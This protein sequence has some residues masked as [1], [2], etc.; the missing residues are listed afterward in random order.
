MKCNAYY[1]MQNGDVDMAR[2]PDVAGTAKKDIITRIR[3]SADRLVKN[4]SELEAP[5]EKDL[6][7]V[8]KQILAFFNLVNSLDKSGLLDKESE[9]IAKLNG[10]I[11]RK[12][13]RKAKA[14]NLRVLNAQW[15][16]TNTPEAQSNVRVGGGLPIAFQAAIK[17]EV[18]NRTDN[19]MKIVYKGLE[20]WGK[21]ISKNFTDFIEDSEKTLKKE[22]PKSA[23]AVDNAHMAIVVNTLPRLN[24]MLSTGAELLTDKQIR[25]FKDSIED[26][27]ADQAVKYS[28]KLKLLAKIEGDDVQQRIRVEKG[29]S[30]AQAA[31][32]D[33]VQEE[34][35]KIR[36]AIG[37]AN[38]EGAEDVGSGMALLGVHGR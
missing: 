18:Q 28:E 30:E 14:L 12:V 9:F 8:N 36:A 7:A 21:Y 27:I 23:V 34:V 26:G 25:E 24:V 31:V 38:G 19:D 20:N 15:R 37:S 2:T 4:V 22:K 6:D 29:I 17:Q 1:I 35:N 16:T 10:K 33:F 32:S 5:T 13:R 11:E 3:V